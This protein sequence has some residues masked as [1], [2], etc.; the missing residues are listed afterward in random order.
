MESSKINKYKYKE[1]NIE[2]NQIISK[3]LLDIFLEV[4]QISITKK[5]K[6]EETKENCLIY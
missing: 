1:M 3:F 4:E 6:S 5:K 2:D